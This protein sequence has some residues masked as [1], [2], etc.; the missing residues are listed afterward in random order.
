MEG[1]AIAFKELF[2]G[3]LLMNQELRSGNSR[4]DTVLHEAARFGKRSVVELILERAADLLSARKHFGETA[5][6]TPL[7]QVGGKRLSI[8]SKQ[9]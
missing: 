6:S 5:P 1:D 2:K 3:G 9:N 7:L 8:C 4:G